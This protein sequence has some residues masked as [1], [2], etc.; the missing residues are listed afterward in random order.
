MSRTRVAKK[1]IETR[2]LFTR[3]YCLIS[4][5]TINQRFQIYICTRGLSR[6]TSRITPNS[7]RGILKPTHSTQFFMSKNTNADEIPVKSLLNRLRNKELTHRVS[8]RL[9]RETSAQ[10]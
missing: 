4:R 8:L 5:E 1:S 7:A 3:L 2:G 10:L 6:S 9:H